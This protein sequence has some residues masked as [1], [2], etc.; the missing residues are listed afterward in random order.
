M[1]TKDA[2]NVAYLDKIERSLQEYFD[3]KT[4][5]FTIDELESME[6]MTSKEIQAFTQK[7]RGQSV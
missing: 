5:S 4:V 6:K 2:R 3:G 1:L 7:R